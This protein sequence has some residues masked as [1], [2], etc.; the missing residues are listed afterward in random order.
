M[1][2][3]NNG[4]RFQRGQAGEM[5]AELYFKKLGWRMFRTQP[6]VTILAVLTGPIIQTLNRFI[7]RLAYFG[8]MVVARMSKGGIADYTGYIH[9]LGKEPL[10]RAVEVKEAKGDA[11]PASRLDKAQRAF[12][13]A[14]PPGCGFIGILWVD[15]GTFQMCPYIKKGSYKRCR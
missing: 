6:P 8:S 13:D 7:P 9:L 10:Y 4:T 14:L 2:N 11:M 12:M 15:H 3:R 5:A 1:R